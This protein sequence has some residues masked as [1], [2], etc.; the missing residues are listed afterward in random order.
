MEPVYIYIGKFVFWM[1]IAI[2]GFSLATFIADR[3]I[4]MILK[5][6]KTWELFCFFILNRKKI[7]KYFDSINS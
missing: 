4:P 3:L 1:T 2:G 7:K 6:I 5:M